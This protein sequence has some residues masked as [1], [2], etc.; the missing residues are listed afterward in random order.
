M[1]ILVTG[2][3]GNIGKFVVDELLDKGH[4]VR[5]FDLKKPDIS[6]AVYIQGSI[7]Q[8][9]CL[10]EAITGVNAVIH[11]AAIPSL[12]TDIPPHEYMNINVTGTYNVLEACAKTGV[13]KVVAA[14]SDSALGFV[15]STHNFSP[16]YFPIDEKHPLKP[17]DPYGL[18]KLLDEDICKSFTRRY[19]ISTICLRFCWVWFPET[20][21]HRQNIINNEE[22][23]NA[24]R[25]WG[26][27]D[28]K[29][30]ARACRLAAECDGIKHEAL[31]ISSN[32]TFT[33]E[34]SLELI[35]KYYP[36]VTDISDDFLNNSYRTIFDISKARK[37][38][39]YNP[40]YSWRNLK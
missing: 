9:E 40:E 23:L 28:A 39:G 29:D 38:I 37:L 16:Q 1:K 8:P 18:S 10:E 11:L 21:K 32:D 34:K 7:T 13:K 26:Y 35:R 4:H 17:Q 36:D 33:Q 12:K 14:S 25:M 2:G 19:G 6:E 5:I 27:V 15:F 22:M 20:Y 3:S 24:K 30:V 31:F